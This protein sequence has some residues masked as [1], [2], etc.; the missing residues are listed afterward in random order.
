MIQC[1]LLQEHANHQATGV[2]CVTLNCTAVSCLLYCLC[3]DVDVSRAKPHI[4]FQS[5]SV[6]VPLLAAD[7]AELVTLRPHVYMYPTS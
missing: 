4:C 7:Y 2:K 1:V 3:I 5:K 6:A